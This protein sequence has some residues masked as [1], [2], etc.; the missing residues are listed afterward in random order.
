ME[1]F[2]IPRAIHIK[3]SSNFFGFLMKAEVEIL[4]NIKILNSELKK[5]RNFP[6]IPM[7]LEVNIFPSPLDA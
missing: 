4:V 6:P 3:D 7:R 1:S 2:R 5:A